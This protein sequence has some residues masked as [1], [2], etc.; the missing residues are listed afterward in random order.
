MPKP[1]QE[2]VTVGDLA[3][4]KAIVYLLK[5]QRTAPP[6]T[7]STYT[8]FNLEGYC[9]FGLFGLDWFGWLACGVFVL[10]LG[11]VF[12]LVSLGHILVPIVYIYCNT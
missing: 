8:F 9:G 2:L 5:I 7:A 1:H 11:G 10:V 4:K 6:P 3:S 12:L